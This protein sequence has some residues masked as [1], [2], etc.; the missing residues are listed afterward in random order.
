VL[1]FLVLLALVVLACSAQTGVSAERWRQHFDAELMPFWSMPSA[2]GSPVGNFPTTRCN[3]GASLDFARPC[4]E[5]AGNAWLLTRE[6]YMVAQSRQTYTYCLAFHWTGEERYWNWC[7]AGADYIRSQGIDRA[8]GAVYTRLNLN[9]NLWGPRLEFRNAQEL[10][11]GLLGL[12]MYYFVSRDPA[13]LYDI[14]M[15]KDFILGQL[16]NAASNTINWQ[17]DSNG[18]ERW[19][20]QRLVAQ[21][22]QMNAYL[23]LIAP[24]LPERYREETLNS[25]SVLAHLMIDKFYD[26][27]DNL[28]TLDLNTPGT[29]DFGHSIK[30]FWMIRFTA[31][32][33]ADRNLL[34][35]AEANGLRLLDRAFDPELGAWNNEIRLDG[36]VGRDKSWW[37][38]AELDQFAAT[39]AARN[40]RLW[41]MLD[42]TQQYWL[43]RFV[44]KENGEVW[45]EI[46]AA[47]GAPQGLGKQWPWKN[48]YHSCEHAF[49]SWLMSNRREE[50]SVQL[51]FAFPPSEE[52]GMRP[53]A[54]FYDAFPSAAV[55]QGPFWPVV[56]RF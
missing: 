4:P 49:V 9:N 30:A 54:Y 12:S 29:R 3:N 53:R 11:Y 50:R 42:R 56:F 44:D 15:T 27:G 23:V 47:S 32:L 31:L 41:S 19:D 18:N 13:A 37:V 28:F 52:D 26:P 2:L 8:A 48:G 51:F 35:F 46:N 38:Y 10:A 33:T 45:S 55:G 5:V 43:D 17:L 16:Y 7:K 39:M 36:S 21:L 40:P 25:L 1:R 22:D 14:L 6:K 34:D 20:A 24:I